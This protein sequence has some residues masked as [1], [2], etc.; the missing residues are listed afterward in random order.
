MV[1]SDL[2]EVDAALVRHGNTSIY[3]TASD[4]SI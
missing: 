1:N 4:Y 3:H 2:D